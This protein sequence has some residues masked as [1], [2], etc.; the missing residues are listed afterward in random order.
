MDVEFMLSDSLEV[1]IMG[2][3]CLLWL[4]RYYCI[5]RLSVRSLSDSRPLKR[6]LS[7]SMTSLL[8]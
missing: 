7:Q 1:R 5:S 2:L 4:L 3:R 6:R 8:P